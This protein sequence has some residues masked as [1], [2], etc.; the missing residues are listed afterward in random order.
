M[1]VFKHV[2][3]KKEQGISIAKKRGK[4]IENINHQMFKKKTQGTFMKNM[5]DVA[6]CD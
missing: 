5:V 6:K 3:E 2:Y 4:Q 1:S